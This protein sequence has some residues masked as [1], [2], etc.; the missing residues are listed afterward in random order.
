MVLLGGLLPGCPFSDDYF[1]SPSAGLAG[2]GPVAGGEGGTG[3]SSAAAGGPAAGGIGGNSAA[4]GGDGGTGGQVATGGN[5][6][7]SAGGNGGTGG[8]SDTGG[9]G[10]A[11]GEGG[12]D[13][14][15]G[16]GG[17]GGTM[18]G[19]VAEPERCD[20]VSNDCDDEID[21]DG[22][23]PA[24]CTAKSYDDHVYLLCYSEDSAD[25]LGADDATARCGDLS[26]QFGLEQD[27]GLVWIETSEEND[28]LL[29][30]IDETTSTGVLWTGANDE[31]RET[32]WV[33]GRSTEAEQF[34]TGSSSG[35]GM[36][37]M[38]RFDDF[39]SGQ[40]DGGDHDD[41]DCGAFDSDYG[42]QWADH[43]CTT[44]QP[45]FICE[46]HPPV[47]AARLTQDD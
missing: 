12:V 26:A 13:V 36:P 34:Y 41:E 39:A 28:F 3:G 9:S 23:C 17:A 16:T 32:T 45:G 29:D 8:S 46:Q 11:G 30:W 20:G 31:N 47:R 38:D 19:C 44:L 15:P 10:D 25:A 1:I 33:W 4:A 43:F 24:A 22:V 27:L 21:E 14:S 40:P 42:W 18:T 6:A 7:T 5:G 2:S 37:Y 35:D